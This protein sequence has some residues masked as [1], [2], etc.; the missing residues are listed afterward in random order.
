MHIKNNCFH[1]CAYFFQ[2]KPLCVRSAKGQC[3]FI[4]LAFGF[5]FSQTIWNT[6]SSQKRRWSFWYVRR[7]SNRRFDQPKTVGV[8]LLGQQSKVK[9]Y[10]TWLASRSLSGSTPCN[11]YMKNP[12]ITKEKMGYLVR[13]SGVEP[14]SVASEATVLSIRLRMRIRFIMIY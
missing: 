5:D 7:E 12:I 8:A 1:F 9:N 2:N 14:E 11:V 4:T 3:F 6:P 13:P 10:I